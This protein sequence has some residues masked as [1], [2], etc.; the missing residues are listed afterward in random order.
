MVGVALA[1]G[2]GISGFQIR[3]IAGQSVL[4]F[5]LVLGCCFYRFG[6]DPESS[7]C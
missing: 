3:F 6:W 5:G 1:Y 2:F 7:F 4:D